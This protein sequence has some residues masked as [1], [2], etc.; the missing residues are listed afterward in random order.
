MNILERIKNIFKKQKSL[1]TST[2]QH[3][4][5]QSSE[6]FADQLKRK[7][8]EHLTFD[9]LKLKLAEEVGFDDKIL[10]LPGVKEMLFSFDEFENITRLR[11]ENRNEYINECGGI[12]KLGR[13][14]SN[15]AFIGHISNNTI[16]VRYKEDSDNYIVTQHITDPVIKMEID[17]TSIYDKNNNLEMK[18]IIKTKDYYS[19][20]ANISEKR[21]GRAPKDI[22]L[23]LEKELYDGSDDVKCCRLF[24]ISMSNSD[25]A[26][27]DGVNKESTLIYETNDKNEI[28]NKWMDFAKESINN[29]ERKNRINEKISQSK[30]SKACSKYLGIDR[31]MNEQIK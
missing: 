7:A 2:E 23:I 13:I 24:D 11:I 4:E 22:A 21:F 20:F 19:G 26:T 28:I 17:Q 12:L 14:T 8:N 10:N 1:P 3:L 29:N 31:N 25:I 30:Y 16:E 27:L 6:S 15:G 5:N 9:Q 18:R